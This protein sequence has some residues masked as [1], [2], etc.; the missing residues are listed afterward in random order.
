V[1][2]QGLYRVKSS[3]I[4]LKPLTGWTLLTNEIVEDTWDVGAP[5]PPGLMP[6]GQP[7]GRRALMERTR[8]R[9]HGGVPTS[10]GVHEVIA[11]LVSC[12]LSTRGKL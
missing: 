8:Y 4:V 11:R 9:S 12:A 3:Q 10:G 1:L 2:G 6:G 5:V 7:L